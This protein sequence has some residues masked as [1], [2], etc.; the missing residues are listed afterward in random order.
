MTTIIAPAPSFKPVEG[1]I[2]QDWGKLAAWARDNGHVF[3]QGSV[4]RQFAGG[5][6]NLNYLI[7]FDG[8]DAVLRRP[9]P[10]PTPAGANDMAREFRVLR[11]LE[12]TSIPTPKAFA[13]SPDAKVLGAP[14]LISQYCEGAIVTG[15]SLDATL[16]QRRAISTMLIEQLVAL[17]QVDI[18]S[19][20]LVDLGKPNG[21]AARTLG[22]WTKRA[23]AASDGEIS[24][25]TTLIVNWLEANLPRYGNAPSLLHND[26]KLDNVV[27]NP[28]DFSSPRAILDWDQATLGD[29]L[30]DLATLLSYWTQ[31]TDHPALLTMAQMPS[32]LPGFL[33]RQ[34]AVGLYAK[35]A[36]I[37]LAA[38]RF[39][40][41][42]A[43]FKLAVVVMQLHARY[44][45]SPQIF[46]QFEP[47]EHVVVALLDF[48]GELTFGDVV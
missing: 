36:K 32:A 12:T 44:R 42:L 13:F 1:M 40:R 45:Q 22:G 17:H 43:Q 47:L 33:S 31:S 4:P 37:N 7:K 20:G 11:A 30:F 18:A 6:G 24:K 15:G 39:Y 41:V 9:P 19:V 21:F 23:M 29:R 27:L 2:S 14:F 34:E 48:C 28:N 8:Q 16:D 26:F 35:S 5:V 3:D 46:A 25:R 10:G 38:F